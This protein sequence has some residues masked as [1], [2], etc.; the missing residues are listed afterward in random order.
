MTIGSKDLKKLDK[1]GAGNK[2]VKSVRSTG[3]R[4]TGTS[5]SKKSEQEDFDN[6]DIDEINGLVKQCE[7]EINEANRAMNQIIKKAKKSPALNINKDIAPFKE[8]IKMYNKRQ[9]WLLKIIDIKTPF[10]EKMPK[11]N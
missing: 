7:D 6:M 2:S 11:D 3:T 10:Y 9:I 8:A 5:R 4:R 1:G